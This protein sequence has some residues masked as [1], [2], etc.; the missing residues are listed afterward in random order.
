M[1]FLVLQNLINLLDGLVP[2]R[3]VRDAPKLVNDPAMHLCQHR[4]PWNTFKG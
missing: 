2:V 4:G 3:I 1:L